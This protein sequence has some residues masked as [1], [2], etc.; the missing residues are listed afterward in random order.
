MTEL[1][2][3]STKKSQS[4]DSHTSS[5][6]PKTASESLVARQLQQAVAKPRT[7]SPQ[8]LKELNHRYGNQT[9]QRLLV[10][11]KPAE[12]DSTKTVAPQPAQT[13]TVQRT[14]T[15]QSLR[16]FDEAIAKNTAFQEA[17]DNTDRVMS[18]ADQKKVGDITG[19]F[20]SNKGEL[21]RLADFIRAFLLSEY[22]ERLDALDKNTALNAKD[23]K[24]KK[25]IYLGKAV[26]L[27]NKYAPLL[28]KGVAAPETQAFLKDYGFETGVAVSPEQQ[29]KQ[30]AKGPHIDVRSTFIGF[31]PLGMNLR[32]HLFIIYTSTDGKQTFIRGGP[33]EPVGTEGQP[34]YIED[35][36]TQVDVGPYESD[37]IDYDP[38][39]PSTTVQKG[40]KA[41]QK[42]DGML[43][44]A[45]RVN[46]MQ[47]PYIGHKGVLDGENC[48]AA[49]YTILKQAGLPAKKP[50]GIHPGWGHTL[51]KSS[52]Q[53]NPIGPKED[54]AIAGT[55][56]IVRGVSAQP[57]DSYLD[58]Q[59]IE[60]AEKIPNATTVKV[61][62]EY[63]DEDGVETFKIRYSG[64]IRFIDS[65][66]MAKADDDSDSSS[67]SE[68]SSEGGR[69]RSNSTASSSEDEDMVIA[70][71]KTGRQFK[72]KGDRRHQ[73]A[74][75]IH[76][77]DDSW[78]N[79]GK[80]VEV[81]DDDF[82][83]G[84]DEWKG[85]FVQVR[86]T[87]HNLELVGFISGDA[88][89]APVGAILDID[90]LPT[91]E[92]EPNEF[93]L[94]GDSMQAHT[95]YGLDKKPL[96]NYIGSGGESMFVLDPDF[97]PGTPKWEDELIHVMY[98]NTETKTTVE[99]YVKGYSLVASEG[100]E[101][102]N[103][104]DLAFVGF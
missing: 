19:F 81:L 21:G 39:A 85:Q 75:K 1:V 37:T 82:E 101:M 97:I 2:H 61:I 104:E 73:E 63:E 36:Y 38:S 28:K 72:V 68:S 103:E 60:K 51:G 44:A 93:V 91:S 26:E 22:V 52:K 48:N 92:S 78:V 58:R 102:E 84:T 94:A 43:E 53:G 95:L 20:Q 47:V 11:S 66:D 50:T 10:N 40:N 99:G 13:K 16:A 33:G 4:Q 7:A 70:T 17:K 8:T 80:I 56:F 86:Y 64:K 32:A 74:L 12:A 49:A 69:S 55:D 45:A 27:R 5:I 87:V 90:K 88:L 30:L 14:L 9:V 98:M 59:N 29:R 67:E 15:A 25:K 65:R 3:K 71:R 62:E 54:N 77:Q 83:P 35:G 96:T 76:D 34:N 6:Q 42:L 57:I 23:K 31:K 89:E 41:K 100:S 79:G 18:T 24:K 46:A